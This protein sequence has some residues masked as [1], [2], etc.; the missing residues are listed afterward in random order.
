[1]KI[2]ICVAPGFGKNVFMNNVPLQVSHL[3]VGSYNNDKHNSTL[4][5][6]FVQVT[7]SKLPLCKKLSLTGLH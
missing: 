3:G 5:F 4:K 6:L 7:N 2:S 1:M